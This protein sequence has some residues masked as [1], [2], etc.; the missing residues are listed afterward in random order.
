MVSFPHPDGN[1][2]PN[3]IV[4]VN[5]TVRT[6]IPVQMVDGILVWPC[7]RVHVPIEVPTTNATDDSPN[8]F[9]ALDKPV[10]GFCDNEDNNNDTKWCVKFQDIPF[11]LTCKFQRYKIVG[12]N[13]PGI[14]I[15]FHDVPLYVSSKQSRTLYFPVSNLC[16]R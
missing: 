1:G 8:N 9:L 14:T 13:L 6:R 5:I 16:Q 2:I 11:T 15:L 12:M 7:L 4:K 3:A 10:S